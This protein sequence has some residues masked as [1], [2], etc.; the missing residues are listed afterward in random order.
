MSD[1]P[2]PTPR[3]DVPLEPP[4][5]HDSPPTRGWTPDGD[6]PPTRGWTPLSSGD[7]PPT[8]WLSADMLPPP[9]SLPT[10]PGY[11]ILDRLGAG[12]M[13]VVYRA[14]QIELNRLVALKVIRAGS[15]AGE[16]EV[17][18][19]R[20]EAEAVARLQHPNVVQIFEI[21][22]HDGLP[23]FALEL[24]E[25]GS[26]DGRLAGKPQPARAAALLIATL[27]RAVHAAHLKGVL[28]RDLKP[29]NVLITAEGTPKVTDFG[30]AKRLDLESGQTHSGAVIG[31]PSYMAPEQALGA[32]QAGPACDVYGLGAI[33]YETL[34][35]RPPFKGESAWDT[36]Q[37]VVRDE[38]VPPCRLQPSAPR[39]LETICLKCLAKEPHKRYAS[40]L[41]LAEDLERYLA[42]ESIRARPVSLGERAV[43]WARRRPAVAALGAS[44]LL[45]TLVGVALVFL[46]WLRAEAR[47]SG[48]A[49]A[50]EAALLATEQESLAKEAALLAR[51]KADRARESEADA[52]AA[53][54]R[55]LYLSSIPLAQREW[56][57]N[58]AART[59][60]LLNGCP[61][62]LRR[63]E[64]HHLKAQ[65]N[66]SLRTLTDAI[67]RLTGVAFHPDG[68]RIARAGAYGVQLLDVDSGQEI[69]KLSGLQGRAGMVNGVAFRPDG[70]E[71]AAGGRDG[72]VLFWDATTGK[73]DRPLKGHVGEVNA[74]AFSA[75][76][77]YLASAGADG[78]VKVWDVTTRKELH[79][80][81]GHRAGVD[82]VA[83]SKDGSRVASAGAYPDNS[84]RIWDA[85]TGKEVLKLTGHPGGATGVAFRPNGRQL[86]SVGSDGKL[87]IW[88][89]QTGRL[90]A[91][92]AA[93]HFK[94]T[95][96]A[97]SP[98]GTR[99]AS[100][101]SDQS[102]KVWRAQN[103]R[104]LFT[105]RGH[106]GGLT[107]VAFSPDS[108]R[109]ASAGED[110]FVKLWRAT[111]A[112][113]ALTVQAG[114]KA[115]LAA[116][117]VS[118]DGRQVA[119]ADNGDR[120][121]RFWDVRNGKA[122][123]V[124]PTSH[125]KAITH[126]TLSPDGKSLATADAGGGVKVWEVATGRELHSLRGGAVKADDVLATDRLP[127]VA[128]SDKG[129]RLAWA[130]P[131][132]TVRTWDLRSGEEG[133]GFRSSQSLES[134][135][136]RSSDR[137]NGVA[138]S[139]DGRLFASGGGLGVV[140]VWDLTTAKQI[141]TLH[142]SPG[143]VHPL[144]F[145]PDGRLLAA[146][147]TLG[148]SSPSEL[149]VWETSAG[150]AV[151]TWVGH[152]A[153]IRDL[154]FS[155]DGQHLA[156]A[157]YDRTVKVWDS[158]AGRE[159]LTFSR[160]E[161]GFRAALAF[162]P[163][164]RRLILAGSDRLTIWDS[165][166]GREVLTLSQHTGV[167]PKVAFS[168]DGRRLAT[169]GGSNVR[170]WDFGTGRQD[171]ILPWNEGSEGTQTPPTAP[172]C[173][174]FSPAG[175]RLAAGGA[176]AATGDVKVWD[177]AT[178][179]R[180]H[181]LRGHGAPAIAVAFSIDGHVASAS[182]DKTVNLWDGETGLK[183]KTLSGHT[184][185]VTGIAFSP[186]G[187]RLASSSRDRTVRVWDRRSDAEICWEAH[188]G[189][190]TGVAF[191]PDGRLLVSTGGAR[192]TEADQRG[193]V[194]VWEAA[195]GKEVRRLRGHTALARSA[196]FSPDGK[197]IASAGDDRIV[198]LW[199][200][201]TGKMLLAL[202]GH[203]DWIMSLAFSPDGRHVA[204]ASV[205]RT[206]R[207][208]DVKHP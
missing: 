127:A 183:I 148:T 95:A 77:Q 153:I 48:E 168:P 135:G 7:S 32:K 29:A 207:V 22:E 199:D 38:P 13:G 194:I 185:F 145:S 174:A 72:T 8:G 20:A 90:L 16:G 9:P 149:T 206:V 94:A 26:L 193:E 172:F 3:R 108:R 80:L 105:L 15:H 143:V 69:L 160:Q 163:D 106:R 54:E 132:G 103:G 184:D 161:D 97:Y 126:L 156:S 122:G 42:G 98:D 109:L 104:E 11:E 84:V 93:H 36:L 147:S 124:L 157:S 129:R 125:D 130:S 43:K 34:T 154:A 128:F 23:Y 177:V 5:E 171:L 47:A 50:K 144:A 158:R 70:K 167:V 28:H 58:N 62:H 136:F 141:L 44:T 151:A 107:C 118:P 12:G 192:A 155:P 75:D 4:P 49:R 10:V 164:G 55:E 2:N 30:L 68:T 73:T 74:V 196:A 121:V 169:A 83:F 63:W 111:A 150:R 60:E 139:A 173:V 152:T 40:A 66:A 202:P 35:G 134:P 198:R 146:A 82:G 37:Q 131:D 33:F 85:Q 56:L 162:S 190:G 19:F 123:T 1:L 24:V 6:S 27:A 142:V 175:G 53:A 159:L 88:D 208:W 59:E 57:G 140:K 102:V 39:D 112:P 137:V 101:G 170:L 204:T 187:Q 91:L 110:G 201:A 86:A 78:L 67:G 96:V 100:V 133:P 113:D 41:A 120:T 45:V 116:V 178:R 182:L 165:A 119:S 14:R 117:A 25:G 200:A 99:L 92:G 138:F 71:V 81:A 31:T 89:A 115:A 114:P 87:R 176:G 205:D 79:V 195:T 179:R 46:L 61:R 197:R 76:G 64:W 189:T 18:R 186:D 65:T 191:S 21:G 203:Q 188:R 17:T 52:R 181:V 51:G 166:P 180:V